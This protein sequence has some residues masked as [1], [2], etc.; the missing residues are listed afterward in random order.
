MIISLKINSQQL[1]KFLKGFKLSPLLYCRIKKNKLKVLN[2]DYKDYS[3]VLEGVL[4]L[5]EEIPQVDFSIDSTLFL[6]KLELFKEKIQLQI[7]LIEATLI[8]RS[9]EKKSYTYKI[10]CDVSRNVSNNLNLKIVE[11]S[12]PRLS[13]KISAQ[14]FLNSLKAVTIVDNIVFLKF[15]KEGQKVQTILTSSKTHN[16]S[17]DLFDEGLIQDLK[18]HTEEPIVQ[19]EIY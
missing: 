19:T 8:L 15:L 5:E 10:E 11:Q 2:I 18:Y 7:N 17:Q 12:S 6:N 1:L 13:F 4:E 9:L 16:I 14:A 3:G